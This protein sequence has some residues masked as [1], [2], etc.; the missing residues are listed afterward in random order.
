MDSDNTPLAGE[1]QGLVGD[2]AAA[3]VAP[4]RHADEARGTAR[5]LRQRSQ[6]LYKRGKLPPLGVDPG[7]GKRVRNTGRYPTTGIYSPVLKSP[8]LPAVPLERRFRS[9]RE[10]ANELQAR[11]RAFAP[12]YNAGWLVRDAYFGPDARR[13]QNV[14]DFIG[15]LVQMMRGTDDYEALLFAVADALYAS[16]S[17]VPWEP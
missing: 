9:R 16:P 5:Q 7:T 11:M 8:E 3:S 12:I 4:G 10:R 14:M 6:G 13:R 17:G 15:V 2:P 1:L